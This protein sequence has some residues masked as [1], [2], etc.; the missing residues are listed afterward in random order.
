MH[1]NPMQTGQPNGVRSSDWL[2][3]EEGMVMKKCIVSTESATNQLMQGNLL[4]PAYPDKKTLLL[5]PEMLES[6]ESLKNL[7]DFFEGMH[8]SLLPAMM[9]RSHI[10]SQL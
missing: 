7:E 6:E 2:D 3:P 1:G 8:A 5:N 4:C 9:M 10:P